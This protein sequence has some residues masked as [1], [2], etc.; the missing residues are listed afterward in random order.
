MLYLGPNAQRQQ[1]L[2]GT[3][4]TGA[5]D[6][7]EEE[8]QQK[9]SSSNNGCPSATASMSSSTLHMCRCLLNMHPAADALNRIVL[10]GPPASLAF[11][12]LKTGWEDGNSRRFGMTINISMYAG[13]QVVPPSVL[14]FRISHLAARQS[15]NAIAEGA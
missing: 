11:R 5:A 4:S 3:K 14:V 9:S 15:K 6:K 10:R 8:Y 13:N 7:R 1:Y 2:Q 12:S